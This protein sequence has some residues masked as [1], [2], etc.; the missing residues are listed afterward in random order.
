M[1]GR[2]IETQRE[3]DQKEAREKGWKREQGRKRERKGKSKDDGRKTASLSHGPSRAVR[4]GP[5]TTHSL[6]A[7]FQLTGAGGP[8]TNALHPWQESY[9]WRQTN[10]PF[11]EEIQSKNQRDEN[12]KNGREENNALY[13][14]KEAHK[15][16]KHPL[17]H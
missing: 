8:F 12:K 14:Q 11:R 2:E 4:P 9:P 13:V 15:N 6:A 5:N 16:D 17:R 10:W 1:R 7:E 3:K